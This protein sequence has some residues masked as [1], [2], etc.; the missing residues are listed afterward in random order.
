M[1]LGGAKML[2]PAPFCH[3]VMLV[4]IPVSRCIL[5]VRVRRETWYQGERWGRIRRGSAPH[6]ARGNDSPWTPREG[7]CPLARPFGGQSATRNWYQIEDLG[8]SCRKE[9][10]FQN[11]RAMRGHFCAGSRGIMPLAGVRGRSP[12]RISP[13]IYPCLCSSCAARRPAR[14]CACGWTWG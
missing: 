10:S 1:V 4:L 13:F 12:R 6:P 8:V 14:A 9:S 5:R 7:K 2:H 3:P 11:G